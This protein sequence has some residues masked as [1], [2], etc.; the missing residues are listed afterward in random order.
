MQKIEY[1]NKRRIYTNDYLDINII[2]IIK[3]DKI[4]EKSFFYLDKQI[5]EEDSK[6]MFKNSQVFLLHYPNGN[7]AGISSGIIKSIIEDEDNECLCDNNVNI[8][9]E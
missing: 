7:E 1:C 2:E 9:D 3:D 4:D 5:F 8:E 6:N